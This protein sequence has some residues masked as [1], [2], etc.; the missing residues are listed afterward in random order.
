MLRVV[1]T[2]VSHSM[3]RTG[4][5]EKV[6]GKKTGAKTCLH[7]EKDSRK[8]QKFSTS[9]MHLFMYSFTQLL[10]DQSDS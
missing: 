7:I 4:L 9:M 1:Q 5:I 6:S 10:V 3:V 8:S 2:S